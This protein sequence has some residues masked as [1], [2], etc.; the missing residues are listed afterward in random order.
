LPARGQ[1]PPIGQEAGGG[2]AGS[3]ATAAGRKSRHHVNSGGWSDRASAQRP[4]PMRRAPSPPMPA[5]AHP[6]NARRSAPACPLSA[7]RESDTS[8]SVALMPEILAPLCRQKAGLAGGILE[9]P[10]AAAFAATRVRPAE[11]EQLRQ[12][13]IRRARRYG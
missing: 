1:E 11:G 2:T 5:T 9:G 8:R 4:T 13:A 12:G 7:N 10:L 6:A 3:R